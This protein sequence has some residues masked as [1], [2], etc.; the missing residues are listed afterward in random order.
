M[1]ALAGLAGN[2][3]G[4]GLTGGGGGVSDALNSAM[5]G[6][7]SASSSLTD[8]SSSSSGSNFVNIGDPLKNIGSILQVLNSGTAV[9]GNQGAE[10]P[11]NV[12]YGSEGIIPGISNNNLLIAALLGVGGF[13]VIRRVKTR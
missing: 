12:D 10:V 6:G 9:N 3:L 11:R 8:E 5:Q 4:G 7:S 13:L 1:A 2:V